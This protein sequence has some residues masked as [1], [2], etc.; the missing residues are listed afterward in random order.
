M[1][2]DLH[3]HTTHSDGLLSPHTLVDTA[4]RHGVK[5]LAVTDHDTVSG[6][7]DAT[8]HARS[9]GLELVPGIE[10]TSAF[11]GREIHILGH[12]VVPT[13]PE[14]VAFSE[15]MRGERRRRVERMVMKLQGVGLRISLEDVLAQS[16]GTTL[17][18]P[19]VAR[20]LMAAGEVDHM[21]EAFDRYLSRGRPG[22]V[23][24]ERPE[25]DAAIR[26]IHEAG[27]TASIAHPGVDGISK[28]ELG[29]LAHLGLDA[30]EAFHPR[31]PPSQAEAFQ[32]WGTSIGLLT[33]GGS[34]FHGPESETSH[35]GAG[36]ARERDFRLLEERAEE[37]RRSLR[38]D[39][40]RW[41]M[42]LDAGGEVDLASD[43]AIVGDVD[44]RSR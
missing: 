13:Q 7:L 35:P 37:R 25:A 10:V 28:N 11:N 41:E 36:K 15:R 31:H 24:R 3:A 29:G 33:T 5:A 1:S 27:G 14:L 18:R 23:E 2:I 21:Q 44:G 34:D 22:W 38:E 16:S 9:V 42:R 40:R 8:R 30:V 12:F 32:R 20:A 4:V 19:H 43:A 6:L 39:I 26:L 17:G